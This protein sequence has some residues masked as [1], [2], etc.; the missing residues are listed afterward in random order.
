MGRGKG[1]G[2]F[3]L[4]FFFFFVFFSFFDS[5]N[6]EKTGMMQRMLARKPIQLAFFLMGDFFVGK[7]RKSGM[8][9][10]LSNVTGV[11]INV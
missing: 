9:N 11:S 10:H 3:S 4:I 1:G 6:M 8:F 7:G 5:M 2:F